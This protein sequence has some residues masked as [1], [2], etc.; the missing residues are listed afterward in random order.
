[1]AILGLRTLVYKVLNLEEGRKW[2]TQ[3]FGIEPYFTEPFYA[4][5]NNGGYEL[6]LFP[7]EEEEEVHGNGSITYWGVDNVDKVIEAMVFLEASIGE[8]PIDVGEGVTAASVIDL[9]N[10]IIGLIYNP[11]FKI[12]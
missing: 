2:Y 5:F 3:A 7:Y 4:G 10:N 1:M 6:G 12:S 8:K 9:W 11:Y